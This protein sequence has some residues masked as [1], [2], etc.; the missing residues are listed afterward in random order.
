M[1]FQQ[2]LENLQAHYLDIT[3]KF[4]QDVIG[5]AVGLLKSDIENPQLTMP[6][7]HPDAFM[8]RAN[9]IG[10]ALLKSGLFSIAENLY[11]VL[12]AQ[13]LEYRG[14]TSQWRHAGALFAN[15][16]TALAAQGDFDKAII[17]LLKAA[18]EDE[19]TYHIDSHHSFAIKD[20]LEAYFGKPI[21]EKALLVAQK[22]NPSITSGDLNVLVGNLG[23][24]EYAFLSYVYIA[25]THEEAKMVFPNEFSYLQMLT[26][27]RN[28]SAL[29]EVSLKTLNGNMDETFHPTLKNLYGAKTWWSS[30]EN[31]RLLVGA[32]MN[33]KI[34]TDTQ[35]KNAVGIIT[36]DDISLFWKSLLVAYI[37]RNYTAHQMVFSGQLVQN[38]SQE[39][40]AHILNVM[41]M[42]PSFK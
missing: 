42:A 22:A 6:D 13:T 9:Q 10:I 3:S 20:M 27:L 33:S 30:F 36:T 18:K 1:E 37:V 41:I 35:L 23:A 26:A 7:A 34:P 11:R 40:L 19:Q 12:A 38:Y 32:T 21:K 39:A 16:G 5:E 29:L 15:A 8:L 25:I 4:Q 14:K 28:L 17:E 31:Q 24:Y 2:Q